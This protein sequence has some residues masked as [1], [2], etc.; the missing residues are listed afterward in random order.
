MTMKKQLLLLVVFA[1]A[2]ISLAQNVNSSINIYIQSFEEGWVNGYY[3]KLKF[4]INNYSDDNLMMAGLRMYDYKNNSIEYYSE[5]VIGSYIGPKTTVSYTYNNNTGSNI[6]QE[7]GW[8]I[9][10]QY[11][12]MTT[13]G[14]MITKK[15]YKPANSISSNIPLTDISDNEEQNE[16]EQNTINGHEYVDLGLGSGNLW[17]K[18]NYGAVSENAYGIYL[19]WPSRLLIQ[20]EWGNEWSTPSRADMI[21]L[22]NNCTFTWGYNNNS[23]YGCKVTGPNGKSIFLPAA[24][25]KIMGSPQKVGSEIYYWSNTESQEGL[26]FALYGS[27]NNGINSSVNQSWNIDFAAFPIRP[28]AN[29]NN[30]VIDDNSDIDDNIEYVDLALPS[31][32]LWAT[33]NVGANK[34][35]ECGSYFAWGET[36]PKN[37]YSWTTYKYAMG[38]ETSLTKYC[39]DSSYGNVDN[40]EILEEQDDAAIVNWGKPWRTPTLSET[41]ELIS[42]CTWTLTTRKGISG[43]RVTGANGN[44]I[45]IPAGG[46]KQYDWRYFT[47][48]SVVM[49]SNLFS[50][51]TSASVLNCQDGAPN[52]WYGWKRCWG[53]NV[54]PVMKAYTDV[55]ELPSI[56][57]EQKV[58]G[59]FDLQ[60]HKIDNY[61]KGLNVVRTKDG[62]VKKAIIK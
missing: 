47:E 48:R 59:I 9:E 52:W 50:S 4:G 36:S 29:K 49:S 13:G 30:T 58:I 34:P 15:V 10:L 16:S 2:D 51:C 8:I 41:Q 7:K 26:A 22:C 21:E 19:E 37:E 17:A 45:F 35:E 5:N 6:I 44:S 32:L 57:K 27:P 40:K 1:I 25:Y 43:Y 62:I 55:V 12:N 60:G 24:G 28:I 39:N 18:T 53:Y 11:F 56:A 61:R 20:S 3:E 54:R 23:V 38:E 33:K 42:Y 14:S 31:G 46:V